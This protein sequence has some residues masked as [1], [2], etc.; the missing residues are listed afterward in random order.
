M[1]EEAD[2][3]LQEESDRR[4]LLDDM[5]ARQLGGVSIWN[6]LEQPRAAMLD[7]NR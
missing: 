6:C 1:N 3:A 2:I 5:V 4:G 7:C